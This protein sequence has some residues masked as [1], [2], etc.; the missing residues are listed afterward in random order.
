MQ[1]AADAESRQ[2]VSLD[3]PRH[4]VAVSFSLLAVPT[5]TDPRKAE[6][7]RMRQSAHIRSTGLRRS[8]DVRRIA[9][10]LT[11]SGTFWDAGRRC[12]L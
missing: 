10:A 11:D 7:R 5:C 1:H 8:R 3:P 12:V 9:C 2:L 6:L 4:A